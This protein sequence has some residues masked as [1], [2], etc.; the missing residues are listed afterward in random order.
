MLLKLK[1]A[2][3][4]HFEFYPLNSSTMV[5]FLFTTLLRL[6]HHYG[7]FCGIN[8]ILGVLL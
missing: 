8:V 3:V 4:F 5:P 1:T 6:M 7:V 2:V